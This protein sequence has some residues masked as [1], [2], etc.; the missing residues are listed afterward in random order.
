MVLSPSQGASN[1]RK[2]ISKNKVCQR[3]RR[4]LNPVQRCLYIYLLFSHQFKQS[5]HF[6]R[7]IRQVS[8]IETNTHSTV[9][10]V[11]QSQCNS[12][13]IWKATPCIN[14]KRCRWS[15]IHKSIS[16]LIHKRSV[17]QVIKSQLNFPH[18]WY[19]YTVQILGNNNYICQLL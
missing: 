3:I 18:F 15:K 11:V 17:L 1:L 19:I 12:T 6:F 8:G 9:T 16:G 14:I 10:K 5:P 2:Y 13:K 7:Q 4:K